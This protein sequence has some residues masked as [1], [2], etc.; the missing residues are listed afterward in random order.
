MV[1]VSEARS[2]LEVL[3]EAFLQYL[4]HKEESKIP[5]GVLLILP[6]ALRRARP[7]EKALRRA[8]DTTPV[9]V[10]IDAGPV[11]TEY[12]DVPFPE[13]LNRLLLEVA[14]LL[15]KGIERHY[16]VTLVIELIRQHVLDMMEGLALQQSEVL[17]LVADRALLTELARL[18]PAQGR[19]VSRFLAA[20][21]FLSQVL[22]VRLFSSV[23]PTILRA[24]GEH[25]NN[26]SPSFAVFAV[27]AV[28]LYAGIQPLARG[29]PEPRCRSKLVYISITA[30]PFSG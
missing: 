24:H 12:R 27:N 30:F 28:L 22:F 17:R 19:D 7:E 11:K 4:R 29:P 14:P 26:K 23:H 13:V 5:R 9:T 6:D 21:V 16:S 10:L 3:K 15:E 18:N 2:T 25:K 8:M 1:T 20:Y